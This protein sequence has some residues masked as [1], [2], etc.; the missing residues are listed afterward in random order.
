M[1]K[2]E[3]EREVRAGGRVWEPPT[4]LVIECSGIERYLG[5]TMDE[6]GTRKAEYNIER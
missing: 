5:M 1:D 3:A 4:C 2:S 6:N